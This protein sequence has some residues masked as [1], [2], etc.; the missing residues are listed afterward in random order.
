MPGQ[1]VF[2]ERAGEEEKVSA[3]IELRSMDS[4]G[5]LSP[6]RKDAR[7]CAGRR[8]RMLRLAGN[9]CLVELKDCFE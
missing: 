6:Q 9:H 5:R 8:W 3:L 1:Y 2:E 4:R 7:R